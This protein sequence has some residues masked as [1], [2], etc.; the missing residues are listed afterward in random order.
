V[1]HATVAKKVRL[2]KERHPE[3]YCTDPT[4]LWRVRSKVHGDKPCPKHMGRQTEE[5]KG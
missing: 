4:C 5:K 1:T 2:D 3:D